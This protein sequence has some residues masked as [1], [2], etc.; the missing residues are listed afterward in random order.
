MD[1]SSTELFI[2]PNPQHIGAGLWLYSKVVA[3]C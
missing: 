3:N 1:I 2:F